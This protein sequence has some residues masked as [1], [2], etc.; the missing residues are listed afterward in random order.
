MMLILLTLFYPVFSQNITRIYRELSAKYEAMPLNIRIDRQLTKSSGAFGLCLYDITLPEDATLVCDPPNRLPQICTIQCPDGYYSTGNPDVACA[1]SICKGSCSPETYD[2]IGADI[3]F[4]SR[5]CT[6][7]KW[8]NCTTTESGL[9]LETVEEECKYSYYVETK[10]SACKL[11]PNDVP[12]GCW[13]SGCFGTCETPGHYHYYSNSCSDSCIPWRDPSEPRFSCKKCSE[14]V[15]L[16][17]TEIKYITPSQIQYMCPKGQWGQPSGISYCM[18]SDGSWYPP[19]SAPNECAIC[20]IPESVYYDITDAHIINIIDNGEIEIKC[21]NGYLGED[22][23]RVRCSQLNGIW[24]YTVDDIPECYIWSPSATPSETPSIT[25][26]AS[27]TPIEPSSEPTRTPTETPSAS[28]SPRPPKTKGSR[29]PSPA[30]KVRGS[31]IPNRV[32]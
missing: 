3:R 23:I 27:I 2:V 30:P 4:S 32:A 1:D 9:C 6:Y 18:R 8:I 16:S 20:I 10:R 28:K 17:N 13:N 21:K 25:P 5:P 7:S 31:M 15:Q 19:A 29:A 14:P 22:A 26:S 11:N 24:N 12:E